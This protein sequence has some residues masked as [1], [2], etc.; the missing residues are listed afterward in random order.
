[1]KFSVQNGTAAAEGSLKKNAKSILIPDTVMVNGQ[2]V[3]VTAIAPKA[4]MGMKKL[5]SATI[6]ANIET[7]GAK[8]FYK[9]KKLK[10]IKVRTVKL[11]KKSVGKK[12][13]GKT[14]ARAKVKVPKAVKKAYK[15]FLYK[16]GLKKSAKIK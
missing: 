13:F 9:C 2:A 4:F 11:T 3:P 8:A 5:K 12:A 7:I 15:K 14:H 16:K 1:M 6:G 10:T